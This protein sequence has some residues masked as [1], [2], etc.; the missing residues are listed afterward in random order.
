MKIVITGATGMIGLAL[1]ELLKDKHDLILILRPNSKNNKNI[2]NHSNIVKIECDNSNLLSLKDKIKGDIFFHLAWSNTHGFE[3][4]NE[5]YSQVKN[6]Q[7]TLD[8]TKLAYYIGCKTFVGAG[9][10][11]EYGIQNLKLTEETPI[12]PQTAYGISK[13]AAGKLSKLLSQELGIKHC[14]TRIL[15]VYGPGETH[16]LIGSLIDSI[17]NNQDFN[18]TPAEQIWN[19]IFSYDCARA[20]FEIA[21]NGK[22]GECYLIAGEEEK[23]L[24]EY[25][26]EVRDLINPNFK[27]NFGKREYNPDQVMYLSADITKLKN[28]TN[29]EIKY[30][31]TEGI[32]KTLNWLENNEK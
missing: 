29:F 8:A 6:I 11:A 20:L 3:N 23:T 25:I 26:L 16:T 15:S 10:Q 30:T 12:N 7:Y 31:F 2:P 19:Y 22:N 24:K 28:D 4:R 14:W 5:Y 32:I 17:I 21:K 1:I 13:Y 27:I 18:T 9:S